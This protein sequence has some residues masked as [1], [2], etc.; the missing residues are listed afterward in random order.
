MIYTVNAAYDRIKQQ[1]NRTSI[2]NMNHYA[3]MIKLGD[4]HIYTDGRE[5]EYIEFNESMA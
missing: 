4:L 2:N 1:V 3:K 5:M